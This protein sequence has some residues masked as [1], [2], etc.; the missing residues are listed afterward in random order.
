MPRALGEIWLGAEWGTAQAMAEEGRAIATRTGQPEWAARATGAQGIIEALRGHHDRALERAAEVEEASLHLG[1]S[2]QLTLAALARA[3]T[4]SG[5]GRYGEA[6]AQLRS[7]FAELTA[8]CTF[9]QLW[10]LSFLAE[11]ALPA[12]ESADARAVVEHIEARTRTGRAPLLQRTLA[13]ANAVLATDEE[14]EDR[15]RVALGP[16]AE[17]WPFLYGMTQFSYGVWLRRRRRV[18]ESREPL[19]A[20]ESVFRALGAKPRADQAASELRATGRTAADPTEGAASWALSPQQL[21]IARLAARGLS[22]RAIGEQLRLSPR[23][24]STHLYRIFPKLDVTSRAQ[25]AAR[26]DMD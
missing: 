23:T 21:A 17:M 26:F 20:A 18:I 6:Y 11:A 15:Y 7:M 13:Y 4:A 19:A 25:L 16:G 10:A 1:Q 9:E 8:P 12:G 22:N 3:L 24:V 5:T 14:A 2:S